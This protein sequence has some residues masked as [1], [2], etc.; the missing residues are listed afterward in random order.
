MFKFSSFFFFQLLLLL[1]YVYVYV[2]RD[3]ALEESMY[4]LFRLNERS[5]RRCTKQFHFT[6]CYIQIKSNHLLT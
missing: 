5:F 2:Y 6:R 3:T 4:F 1:E